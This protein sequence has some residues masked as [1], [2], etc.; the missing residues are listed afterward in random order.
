MPTYRIIVNGESSDDLITAET[1]IDAYFFASKN[2]P[3]NYSK[4]F[5]LV[6]VKPE[7]E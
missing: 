3:I 2:L 4:D 5:K 7:S 1:Y 6:E